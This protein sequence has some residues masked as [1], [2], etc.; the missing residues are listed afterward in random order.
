MRP[1]PKNLGPVRSV[2]SRE[3][4]EGQR[5]QEI[6]RLQAQVDEMREHLKLISSE[7]WGNLIAY[8]QKRERTAISAMIAEENERNVWRLQGEIRVYRYLARQ[9]ED[10]A[11]AIEKGQQ[12]I[13]SLK[14][15]SI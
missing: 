3:E 4:M 13:E 14:G 11:T 5:Q 7:L 15:R 10:V 2:P 1:N 9:P 6:A 12:R 8:M